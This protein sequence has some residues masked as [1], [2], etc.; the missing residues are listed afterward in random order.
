MT[1][2]LPVLHGRCHNLCSRVFCYELV[3]SGVGRGRPDFLV[4][5]EDVV[6]AD[7]NLRLT[8]CKVESKTGWNRVVKRAFIKSTQNKV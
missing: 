5:L 6:V 7:G 1:S 8:N 4:Q 2:H 3:G